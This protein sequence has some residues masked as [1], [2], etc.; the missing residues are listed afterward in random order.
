MAFYLNDFKHHLTDLAE[1]SK[2]EGVADYTE[3]V[4]PWQN[5][6]SLT[7]AYRGMGGGR[8]LQQL[9]E[10][11][12]IQPT[13][14]KHSGSS[15]SQV[16]V[17]MRWP[18]NTMQTQP[19]RRG[20][21]TGP[22]L[23]QNP[24][25]K[26]KPPVMSDPLTHNP[27]KYGVQ[28]GQTR[29]P[30]VIGPPLRHPKYPNYGVADTRGGNNIVTQA[31]KPPRFGGPHPRPA[32]GQVPTI[33]GN[34]YLT[35]ANRPFGNDIRYPENY[36]LKPGMKGYVPPPISYDNAQHQ[37]PRGA[38]YRGGGA[39]IH[40]TARRGMGGPDP[41]NKYDNRYRRPLPM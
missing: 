24:R 6:V 26:G 38:E 13:P 10:L 4:R 27:N 5:T 28:Q 14:V 34:N 3:P 41:Y 25:G 30:P 32:K 2:Q 7:E 20:P 23:T 39:R 9:N 21:Y 8:N 35:T 15:T 22:R 17:S 16:P 31:P 18:K 29:K 11:T 1:K 40:P 19:P 33:Q 37:L 12:P 36:G